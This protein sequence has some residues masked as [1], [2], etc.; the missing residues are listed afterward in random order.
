MSNEKIYNMKFSKIYPL[1]LNK[2]VRKGRKEAEVIDVIQ[3]L[4][5]YSQEFG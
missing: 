5:G 4:T 3:W 1:L 2:A